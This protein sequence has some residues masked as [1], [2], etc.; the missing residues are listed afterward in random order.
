MRGSSFKEKRA[1]NGRARFLIKNNG[2][3]DRDRTCDPLITYHL[4][5]RRP[6][7]VRGLDY[8][9]TMSLVGFRWAPSSLYTFLD[10]SRLG[11]GLPSRSWRE[12]FPDFDALSLARFQT[13]LPI[14][15]VS[16]ST[17]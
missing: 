5:F 6:C 16:C 10:S 8:P 13:R 4:D 17:N 7:W 11:S 14:L 3:P 12:G 1:R 15:R 2:E 9:F